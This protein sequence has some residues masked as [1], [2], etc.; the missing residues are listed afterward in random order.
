MTS[1]FSA[2]PHEV[3]F[4][5]VRDRLGIGWSEDLRLIGRFDDGE[6]V[7]VVAFN[8]LTGSSCH[9]HLCGDKKGW[10][11][12]R[13]LREVF[14]YVFHTLQYNVV[15]GLVPSSCKEALDLD[16]RLGATPLLFLEGAHPDGGIHMLEIRK[17][18]CRWLKKEATD[19]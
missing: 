14:G 19:V 16:L 17:E 9:M 2:E 3:L 10:L 12:R 8:N 5:F 7:G 1:R 4:A 18:T 13:F 11:T 15:Y 6:L